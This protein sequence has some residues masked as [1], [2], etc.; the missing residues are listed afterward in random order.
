MRIKISKKIAFSI[1]LCLQS[2]ARKKFSK[3]TN[4][5]N[6]D[7]LKK[8]FL[9]PGIII[10]TFVLFYIIPYTLY[11]A[12]WDGTASTKSDEQMIHL[13]VSDS[14]MLLGLLADPLTYIFLTKHYRDMIWG[15]LRKFCMMSK[16][17]GNEHGSSI[18]QSTSV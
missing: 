17:Q 15:V 11:H 16:V 6:T 2:K 3:T 14:I 4:G 12:M 5:G 18:E 1:T 9:V 7:T 10:L 13:Y 8:Q